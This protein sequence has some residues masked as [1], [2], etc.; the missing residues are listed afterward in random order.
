MDHIA[1]ESGPE[2]DK[3]PVFSGVAI[4]VRYVWVRPQSRRCWYNRRVHAGS[5]ADFGAIHRRIARACE[6]RRHNKQIL[7]P[8]VSDVDTKRTR[9]VGPK[10]EPIDNTSR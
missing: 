3:T 2:Q 1:V 6:Y 9:C 4:Q 7:H 5:G 8:V 10:H